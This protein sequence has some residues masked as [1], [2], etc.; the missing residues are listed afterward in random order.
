[1]TEQ[2]RKRKRQKRHCD[3]CSHLA[4]PMPTGPLRFH[5]L[6]KTGPCLVPTAF[7]SDGGGLHHS[8][9]TPGKRTD[10]WGYLPGC[11]D[12][13]TFTCVDADSC[14]SSEPFYYC[15]GGRCYCDEHALIEAECNQVL[16]ALASPIYTAELCPNLCNNKCTTTTATAT[17]ITSTITTTTTTSTSA[18][19][20]TT[21]TTTVLTP[22]AT[23]TQHPTRPCSDN[24]DYAF[25]DTMKDL[26]TG[27][28]DDACDKTLAQ[29][30]DGDRT[31]FDIMLYE[32]C[33]EKCAN[34]CST[35][36]ASTSTTS[37]T[38]ASVPVDFAML[39]DTSASLWYSTEPPSMSEWADAAQFTSQLIDALKEDAPD[40]AVAIVE[41]DTD[42]AAATVGGYLKDRTAIQAALDS[43][44]Y[45]QPTGPND[46]DR[47]TNWN[48]A[49]TVVNTE[50]QDSRR[51]STP[52]AV[53]LMTDGLPSDTSQLN[54]AF[55]TAES[56]KKNGTIIIT[57][58]V[59]GRL[60][61]MLA[62]QIMRPPL[63]RMASSEDVA[64]TTDS[65]KDAND[66]A[67]IEHLCP[68]M[69]GTC[70][71]HK[72]LTTTTPSTTTTD[73]TTLLACFSD[74]Y[75]GPVAG[76][77]ILTKVQLGDG[78]TVA[79][80]EECSVL[81]DET[82]DC[83]SFAFKVGGTAETPDPDAEYEVCRGKADPKIC[84]LRADLDCDEAIPPR[85]VLDGWNTCNNRRDPAECSP[86]GSGLNDDGATAYVYSL[87]DCGD[88]GVSATCPVLCSSCPAVAMVI[89]CPVKCQSCQSDPPALC[90]DQHDPDVCKTLSVGCSRANMVTDLTA[91]TCNGAVDAISCDPSK[92]A[93]LDHI[94][95]C[96]VLCGTCEAKPATKMVDRFGCMLCALPQLSSS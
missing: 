59:N 68:A 86:P 49:F 79:T 63:L 92:C 38:C 21:T 29:T 85:L 56:M 19:A 76:F 72:T 4:A 27:D 62:D 80:A 69:C 20:T 90:N 96:P 75:K 64:I 7:C 43:V 67:F 2:R 17:T 31:G 91:T 83:A 66:P 52:H 58:Q 88:P 16:I 1:M 50:F 42:A 26:G 46:K 9:R 34:V 45:E 54:A 40:T 15:G 84:D 95:N 41:Y 61:R 57:V 70:G 12:E 55:G 32:L 93:L 71:Q 6:H 94:R 37:T 48:N 10:Y 39:L 81:C 28:A 60:S 30:Y 77:T 36:T 44:V 24:P 47:A 22:F 53:L 74:K 14:G 89:A 65:F 82:S 33:P 35:T 87:D 78:A 3:V 25:C 13:A 51:P 73:T 23:T 5:A 8:Y 18:T 11:I